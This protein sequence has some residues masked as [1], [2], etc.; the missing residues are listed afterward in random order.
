MSRLSHRTAPALFTLIGAIAALSAFAC[1]G[2]AQAADATVVITGPA[3]EPLPVRTVR[4][5]EDV[6]GVYQMADGRLLTVRARGGALIAELDGQPGQSLR[7]ASGR[8]LSTADK[9][10]TLQFSRGR[11]EVNLVTMTLA[12]DGQAPQ[13]VSSLA[14]PQR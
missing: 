8:V 2:S 10:M 1:I 9:R 7:A 11:D 13:I 4:D 12:A 14:A 5:R 3:A 6:A